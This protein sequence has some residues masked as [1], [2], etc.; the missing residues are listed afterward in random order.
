GRAVDDMTKQLVGRDLVR[1]E[2]ERQLLD[3]EDLAPALVPLGS[4]PRLQREGTLE[5]A[6]EGPIRPAVDPGNPTLE[7]LEQRGILECHLASTVRIRTPRGVPGVQ[8]TRG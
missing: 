5:F 7:P 2:V 4:A 6:P 3:P 1:E 8:S